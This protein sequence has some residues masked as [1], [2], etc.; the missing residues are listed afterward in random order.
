MRQAIGGR[1]LQI[2]AWHLDPVSGCIARDGQSVRLDGR[3]MDLLLYL[4]DRAG[5][6]VSVEELLDRV[7][8]GVIVT[9]DSVY[10]AV[11]SLRR[12][13][14]DE[15]KRPSYIV[16]VPRKGYRLVAEVTRGCGEHEVLDPPS[17]ASSGEPPRDRIDPVQASAEA[18]SRSVDEAMSIEREPAVREHEGRGQPPAASSRRHFLLA[19]VA[20]ICLTLAV[21]S[22]W[23]AMR[24]TAATTPTRSVAVLP[25]LDLT[26]QEMGEEYF[27]DGVTEEL[28][29]RL[30]KL[31]GMQVPSPAS[32]FYFKGKDMPL[33]DIAHRLG[34]TYVLS[35]SVRRSGTNQ[36]ISVRLVRA[37]NGYVLWSHDCDGPVGDE[38]AVQDEI[39]DQVAR[40]LDRSIR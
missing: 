39:A 27:A 16:T 3:T 14:G 2:G 6:V 35:G 37:D 22:T 33:A 25:F 4:A 20:A 23:Y 38:L 13:L 11:A 18:S 31:R 12:L 21:G 19:S 15:A 36:R 9:Q 24:S 30:S 29:D 5:E 34:V 40:A 8:V 10:Q 1:S 28:I 26:S 32:S 7:W 17:A